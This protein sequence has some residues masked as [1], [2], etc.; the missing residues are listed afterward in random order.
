[1]N[2][3]TMIGQIDG[4]ARI[5]YTSEDGQRRLYKFVL[6]VPRPSRKKGEENG[7]DFINVKCWSS[8]VE[9]EDNL[10][11]QAYIGVEGRIQSFGNGEYKNFG[12]EVIATK[13]LYLE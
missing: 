9:D 12:N 5:T 1:M 6:R 4:D 7:A 10:H 11:D 13:I 3:V 2:S 8:K